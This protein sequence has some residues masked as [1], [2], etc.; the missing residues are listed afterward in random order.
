M[1]LVARSRPTRTEQRGSRTP[2]AGGDSLEHG[3]LIDDEGIRMMV[4]RRT[5]LVSDI[6]N[7]DYLLGR[8][9]EIKLPQ[10]SVDKERMIGQVQRENF[11]KCVKA[12]VRI[13]YGT[14]AGVYPHGD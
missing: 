1:L 7:D 10:E 14:D 4:D 8:A 6:Y 11:A 9:V 13:A 2:T 3:S 5:W 12:G